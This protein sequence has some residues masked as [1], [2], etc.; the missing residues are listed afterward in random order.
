MKAKL[1]KRLRRKALDLTVGGTDRQFA[2]MRHPKTKLPDHL[3]NLAG[4]TRAVYRK[5]K[6]E[7]RK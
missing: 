2:V 4:T 6:R 5:L 1:C 7:A 3:A